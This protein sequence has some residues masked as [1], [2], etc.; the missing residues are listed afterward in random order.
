MLLVLL[1]REVSIHVRFV[2]PNNVAGEATRA[3]VNMLFERF[4]QRR[5]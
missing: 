2:R 1:L 4:V 3:S 5:G